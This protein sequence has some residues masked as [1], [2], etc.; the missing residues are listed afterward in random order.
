MTESEIMKAL[1][2]CVTSGDF[3]KSQIE[4]CSPCPYF[5]LGDCTGTLKA[6][7]LYLLNSKNAEIDKS[8]HYKRL[9]EDLK[10]EHIE[11]I[12]AIRQNEKATRTEAIKEFAERIKSVFVIDERFI[13]QIAKEM[14][15]EV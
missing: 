1:E 13:D 15:V 5:N 7:A 9:Y 11:T 3:T 12:K 8:K 2:C 10:A 4:I 6:N 14:G